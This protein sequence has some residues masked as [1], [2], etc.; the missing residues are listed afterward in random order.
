M[1]IVKQLKVAYQVPPL[2]NASRLVT[3]DWLRLLAFAILIFYHIGML[4]SPHWPYHIKSQYSE[5]WVEF[6]MLAVNPWRMA[7]LWLISGVATRYLLAKLTLDSFIWQRSMRLLLP[8]FIGVLLIVPPQLYCQMTFNGDLKMSFW[9]FMVEFYQPNNPLFAKYDDGIWPHV[10]VNHLW[11]LRELWR[12][13]LY[14]VLAIPLLHSQLIER[15]VATLFKQPLWRVIAI[16]WLLLTL[17]TGWSADSRNAEGAYFLL[18]GY[19]IAGHPVFW[20]R[21]ISHIRL[22]SVWAVINYLLLVV[23]YH[24]W[25]QTVP[26]TSWWHSLVLAFVDLHRLISLFAV[27]ALATRWL[28]RPNGL[29]RYFAPAVYPFYIVHQTLLIVICFAL[30]PYQLGPILEPI[31]VIVGTILGCLMSYELIRRIH[32][33]RPLFGVKSQMTMSVPIRWILNIVVALFIIPFAWQIMF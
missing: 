18:L 24:F 26:V 28:R 23:V 14:L 32:W 12:F 1:N 29:L 13:T 15:A 10:D 19:L 3:L 27:M 31:V 17:V 2:D 7:L 4:Y 11:Y 20:Q 22:W 8:L 6:A 25:W 33:L 5:Y 30:T 9:Q 21:L 16:L